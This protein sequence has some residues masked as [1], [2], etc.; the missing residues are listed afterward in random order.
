MKAYSSTQCGPIFSFVI[1][2]FQIPLVVEFNLAPIILTKL[3]GPVCMISAGIFSENTGGMKL[4][5][6]EE[7]EQYLIDQQPS[8][9]SS[10]L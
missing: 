5:L 8:S 4:K 1:R 7:I 10:D 2:M 9:V 3:Y 6:G